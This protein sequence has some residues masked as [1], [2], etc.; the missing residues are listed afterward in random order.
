MVGGVDMRVYVLQIHNYSGPSAVVVVS[1]VTK[2]EIPKAHPHRLVGRECKDGVCTMKLS[3][4]YT[5][6][7]VFLLTNEEIFI[8]QP[9][10]KKRSM[11]E[12]ASEWLV[13]CV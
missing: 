12:S 8:L 9:T 1:L 6:S 4:T 2:D 5:I 3:N 11:F 7:Y 10:N 13:A